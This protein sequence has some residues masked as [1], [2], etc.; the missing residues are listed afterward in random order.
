MTNN[1]NNDTIHTVR[2][3]SHTQTQHTMK[4]YNTMKH[5][6]K[7]R[8]NT[9]RRVRHNTKVVIFAVVGMV[10][11]F[12]AVGRAGYHETHYYRNAIVTNVNSNSI[13]TVTDNINNVWEFEGEGYTE[14]DEVRLLM[15]NHCTNHI[16]T[17]DEVIN[18]K[19]ITK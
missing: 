3:R 15:F 8:H 2:K 18:A 19:V 5:N 11:F 10:L 13:V 12:L 14:G 1:N 4:G 16:I 6:N 9:H 17:D 7:V